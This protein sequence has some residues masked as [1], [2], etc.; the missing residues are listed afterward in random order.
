M[1]TV[2]CPPLQLKQQIK[3]GSE[4]YL[5]YFEKKANTYVKMDKNVIK[6]IQRLIYE[7]PLAISKST[8]RAEQRSKQ[9]PL[10]AKWNDFGFRTPWKRPYSIFYR[11]WGRYGALVAWARDPLRKVTGAR[12]LPVA[13]ARSKVEAT[14]VVGG[15]RICSF[16]TKVWDTVLGSDIYHGVYFFI[17]TLMFAG[18]SS[19]P[20]RC[21]LYCVCV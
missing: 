13:S 3:H 17:E 4:R 7:E 11:H 16:V 6:E 18:I 5:Y 14:G 12:D 1:S 2:Q 21:R 9:E 8:R 19:P 15:A 20:F 10:T